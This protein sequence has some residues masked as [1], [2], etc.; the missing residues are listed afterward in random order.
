M[1]KG[2]VLGKFMP[3]HKGH[4]ALIE[5]GLKNCDQLIVL[6]CSHSAEP[7]SGKLRLLWLESL[8]SDNNKIV[9]H[10]FLYDPAQLSDASVSSEA[11]SKRW[12]DEIKKLFPDLSIIFSSEPYGKYLANHLGIDH[13]SYDEARLDWPVS[14]SRIRKFP[15]QFWDYL[16]DPVKPWFVKKI[17][18]L[19]SESTGK[20]T[21][22][23]KLA[24]HYQTVFVPEMAR[25]V[26]GHTN[27]CS[28][29]DLYQIAQLQ[30]KTITEKQLHANRFLFIDTDFNIT[31]SYAQFL[32]H[33][34]LQLP[35]WIEEA[36]KADLYL[37][38]ETDCPYVQDGT[39]LNQEERS[40]LS[41]AHKAQLKK[42]AITYR[43][44]SGK[45]KERFTLACSLVDKT[46][47]I[48]EK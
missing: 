26:I 40:E 4:L 28:I 43:T 25:E 35:H 13:L 34:D 21:L 42:A 46:F 1:K 11:D 37:F 32:F 6:L 41:K 24:A 9:V 2:L 38:L 8:F 10:S 30:A 36:S 27:E 17:V 31:R 23:E 3:P 14:S 44:I 20:S 5:F 39:R 18:L 12:G 48:P 16:P 19:G 33:Q 47:F 45:W 15:L 29:E 7:I 22:A